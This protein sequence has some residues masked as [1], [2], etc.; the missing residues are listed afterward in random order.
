[1][2]AEWSFK[3]G[4]EGNGRYFADDIFDCILLNV[5]GG[6]APNWRQTI[7]LI[8]VDQVLCR[9]LV[10]LS[11]N[12][13]ISKVVSLVSVI[14]VY[15]VWII[16]YAFRGP[17]VAVDTL[18]WKP[19]CVLGVK[20]KSFSA[21]A[22]RIVFISFH[23]LVLRPPVLSLAWKSLYLTAFVLKSGSGGNWTSK[24]IVLA[25][26]ASRFYNS[27]GMKFNCLC[28]INVEKL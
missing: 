3:N 11:H 20:T 5:I 9:H 25:M 6:L 15:N 13:L 23:I 16:L 2:E 4:P 21:S 10:S 27:L 1:M 22:H 17:V 8:N 18:R 7:T 12:E 26:W 28:N 19:M 14:F 24:V